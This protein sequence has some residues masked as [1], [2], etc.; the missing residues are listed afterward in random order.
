MDVSFFKMVCSIEIVHCTNPVIVLVTGTIFTRYW[1]WTHWFSIA[2]AENKNLPCR[3]DV[4][5]PYSSVFIDFTLM[6]REIIL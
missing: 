3:D 6:N 4:S 1:S 5:L 2:A